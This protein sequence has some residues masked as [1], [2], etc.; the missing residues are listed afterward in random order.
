ML[1]SMQDA[2]LCDAVRQGRGCWVM[3]P[4]RAH[5]TISTEEVLLIDGEGE[6]KA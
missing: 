3:V 2:G 5:V 1:S 6:F 4:D